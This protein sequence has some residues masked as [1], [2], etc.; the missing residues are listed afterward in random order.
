MNLLPNAICFRSN[1]SRF[2]YALISYVYCTNGDHRHG[3]SEL[4]PFS[5]PSFPFINIM[6]HPDES[7]LLGGD[8]ASIKQK[9]S[10]PI[11]PK[12]LVPQAAKS[13]S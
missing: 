6:D 10:K 5:S 11:S 12:Q 9:H 1:A 3:T 2:P 8:K 7:T 13:V 4:L